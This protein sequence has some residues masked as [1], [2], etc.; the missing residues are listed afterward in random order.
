MGTPIYSPEA[1][2][3]RRVRFRGRYVSS[4]ASL[5]GSPAGRQL[6]VLQAVLGQKV[7]GYELRI[8]I[9]FG[10]FMRTM[11]PYVKQVGKKFSS[12]I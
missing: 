11:L 4:P 2:P 5:A 7:V 3:R 12:K 6:A 9:R 10:P 8:C 1:E